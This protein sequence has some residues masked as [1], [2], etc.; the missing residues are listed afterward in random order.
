VQESNND[1]AG[2]TREYNN[3]GDPADSW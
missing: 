3:G 1:A 2:D